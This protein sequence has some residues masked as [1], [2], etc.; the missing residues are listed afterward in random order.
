[1]I[2]D[3]SDELVRLVQRSGE[4]PRPADRSAAALVRR[5]FG[6]ALPPPFAESVA[7]TGDGSLDLPIRVAGGDD[8]PA[9]AAVKWRSWRVGYRGVVSDDLLDH[10]GVVPTV[11]TW[12]ALA[13]SPPTPRHLLLVTGRPGAVHAFCAIGPSE[14]DDLDPSIT[15]RIRALYVDPSLYRRGVGALLVDE[16]LHRLGALGF[17]DARLW[18]IDRNH[19]A[20]AFYETRGWEPDGAT[21]RREFAGLTTDEVRYRFASS[22]G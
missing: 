5:R 7:T 13:A 22:L 14:D 8:G 21:L 1:M 3:P 19:P 6:L 10:L 11:A 2:Q 20:R 18:V 16:A 15:G 9:I 4:D 12:T 17:V